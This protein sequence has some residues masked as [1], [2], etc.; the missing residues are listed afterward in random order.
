V[1]LNL[2]VTV[3]PQLQTFSPSS[4]AFTG[5]AIIDLSSLLAYLPP[6]GTSGNIYSGNISSPGALI[7]T[8]VVVPEP[9][10]VAQLAL[11]AVVFAGLALVRRARRVAARR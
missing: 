3:S 8:W 9:P 6:T 7:G 5:T 10:A 2:Y 1:D 4:P 11:G